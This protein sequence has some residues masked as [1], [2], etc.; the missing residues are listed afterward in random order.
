MKLGMFGNNRAQSTIEYAVFI[1]AVIAGFIALQVY[2]S[3]ASQGRFKSYTDNVSPRQFSARYSTYNNKNF[4]R[5]TPVYEIEKKSTPEGE[6]RQ[7]FK[8][9]QISRVI[10]ADIALT[11]Q[12]GQEFFGLSDSVPDELKGV[13]AGL[14]A[15]TE[16][17]IDYVTE[18]VISMVDNFSDKKLVEDKLF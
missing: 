2:F 15:I 18:N 17:S 9:A 14:E 13:K 3:R 4:T 1:A 12:N 10:S 5:E 8:T 7:E 16:I 11:I 6:S